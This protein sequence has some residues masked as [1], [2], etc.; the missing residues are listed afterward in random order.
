MTKRVLAIIAILL[1]TTLAWVI[2]G[3]TIM[4][5]SY[6]ADYGLGEK[7]AST[8]GGPQ[9]QVPPTA[10]STKLVPRVVEETVNGKTQKTTVNDAVTKPLPLEQSRIK[11]GL[12][13]EQRQKGLLWFATYRVA[14]SGQYAFRNDTDAE[15][16]TIKLTFPAPQAIYDDLVFTVDGQAVPVTTKD[17]AVTANV[18]RSPGTPFRLAVGY[19]SQALGTWHY[20]LGENVTQVRDF[21]LEMTTDFHDVDFPQGSMSPTEKHQTPK[22]WVL[23]WKYRNLVTGS[24]IGMIMPEK[25][26]PGPLAGRISFFAPVS[27]VFF[28]FLIFVISTLKKIELH[29]MHYFFL[30]TSFFAFHLLLAYLVD[31]ISIHLAFVICSVVSI[32]LVVSYLRIVVGPRFAF[33]EAA[34]AQLVYLVGF[35][36]A[37]FFKG[38]T[39]LA[40]TIG[41]IL[42]LFLVM[43][44]TARVDW[45]RTNEA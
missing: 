30:A 10:I 25:L 38:F 17:G 40:I 35:S 9:E 22:G 43:Q 39:G 19:R 16:V 8:W 18:K 33:I 14:W 44:L 1:C 13:L 24:K 2:L 37:F 4:N 41:A 21:I 5:R 27:L 26:Q 31:H 28:F 45:G 34:L 6:S 42:S 23:S 7:V 15:D 12:D 32:F 3:A 20:S 29:P 11:V 36:Y